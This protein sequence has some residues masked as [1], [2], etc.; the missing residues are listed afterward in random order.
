MGSE[1]GE[2][3]IENR[4]VEHQF[5]M[6]QVNKVSQGIKY[7][8]S[9]NRVFKESLSK[10]FRVGEQLSFID[11]DQGSSLMVKNNALG[12]FKDVIYFTD[13]Q[14]SEHYT[15]VYVEQLNF[16]QVISLIGGLIVFVYAI[17]YILMIPFN[18]KLTEISILKHTS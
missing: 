6:G 13:L 5:T 14:L 3:E 10:L 17:G 16:I 11:V 18:Y 15:K 8:F 4:Y 2:I 9:K 12:E 7:A 1:T